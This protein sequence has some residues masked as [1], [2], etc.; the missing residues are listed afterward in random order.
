M[1]TPAAVNRSPPE[2]S[3][4]V[5][6]G[7]VR[8]ATT[9][10]PSAMSSSTVWWKRRSVR[11]L[12]IVCL[13]DSRSDPSSEP[14]L[15]LTKAGATSSSTK[16]RL[17]L[18]P[19]SDTAGAPSPNACRQFLSLYPTFWQ[20][21]LLTRR[22]PGQTLGQTARPNRRNLFSLPLLGPAKETIEEEGAHVASD[23]DANA[24]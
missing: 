5:S 6:P 4:P 13:N 8:R 2:L 23:A 18:F 24:V 7:P 11:T 15:W 20:T 16:A 21:V 12:L 10:S 19:C 22:R 17:P 1:T 14:A 3:P 9:V